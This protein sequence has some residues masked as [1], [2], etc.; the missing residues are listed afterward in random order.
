M[1]EDLHFYARLLPTVLSGIPTTALTRV[2]F[3][4]G[5]KYFVR[6]FTHLF[7]NLNNL[8]LEEYGAPWGSLDD[9][10]TGSSFPA[11]AEVVFRVHDS[12]PQFEANKY[13]ESKLPK[14]KERRLLHTDISTYVRSR[15][16]PED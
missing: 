13:V 16:Q 15:Y 11:L 6:Q 7:M 1:F 2:L 10:L 12:F 8:R 3:D 9:L 14:C 5:I 4:F